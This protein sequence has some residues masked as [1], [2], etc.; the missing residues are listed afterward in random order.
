MAQLKE[1]EIIEESTTDD[2]FYNV[3]MY[4]DD[5]TPFEYVI[6]VLNR[7]F[8]YDPREGLRIAMTIHQT[9]KAIVATTSMEAAY[10][11]MEAVDK[12]NEEYGFMLQTNVEKV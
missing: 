6:M 1:R 7:I 11:K 5:V 12:M 4:N 2:S 8:G 10:E 9:G 3:V